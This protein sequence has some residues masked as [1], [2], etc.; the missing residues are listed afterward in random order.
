MRFE[1]NS[2]RGIDN[3]K[4]RQKIILEFLAECSSEDPPL[5]SDLL[6]DKNAYGGVVLRTIGE[7]EEERLRLDPDS[8]FKFKLKVIRD[9]WGK[10]LKPGDKVYHKSMKRSKRLANADQ[11]ANAKRM[12]TY[13]KEFLDVRKYEIDS[14]GCITCRFESAVYFL[15]NYGLHA[16]T[17]MPVTNKQE[18]SRN[19]AKDKDGKLTRHLWYWRYQ[20]VNQGSEKMNEKQ[21]KAPA[22]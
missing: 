3:K 2:I 19:A 22:K 12:G 8:T 4:L 20:E 18:L 1:L 7:R 15:N 21:P 14:D 5:L 10:K 16:I 17:G 11:K 6:A 9:E 13:E